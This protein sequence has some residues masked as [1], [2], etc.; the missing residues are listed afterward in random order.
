MK[1]D[2]KR[3]IHN[4]EI[5]KKYPYLLDVGNHNGGIINWIYE[6]KY[7]DQE[8]GGVYVCFSR[9]ELK[10][11]MYALD[12]IVERHGYLYSPYS[13]FAFSGIRDNLKDFAKKRKKRK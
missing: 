10:A 5:Y 3:T 13:E 11:I 8:L 1:Q 4:Q 2:E 6:G 9:E 12:F 7:D